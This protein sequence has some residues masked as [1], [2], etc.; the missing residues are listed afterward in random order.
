MTFPSAP[1][2]GGPSR[3]DLLAELVML[4]GKLASLPAIEQAK[5]ALMVTYGLTADAAFD[6]LRFH[7]QNRNVRI[8]AIAAQLTNLLSGGPT[9][10]KGITRFDQLLDE[11]TRSLQAAPPRTAAGD[12][13]P[14]VARDPAGPVIPPAEMPQVTLRAVA[15]APPGITIAANVP[16]LPLVYANNAF[17][18]LTGYPSGDVLGR[19]CRFLQG[20][21]TDL[22]D[23]ATLRRAL[24][25][26]RDVSV[27]LANYRSDGSPFWNEVSIS[28]IRDRTNQITHFVGTQTDVTAQ[29]EH[30]PTM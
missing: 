18:E 14:V 21:A 20:A 13:D 29:R 26:G 1:D 9:S 16:H 19:N 30:A 17:T 5:G 28:P 4:R 25:A 8:R 6:L 2:A 11:V 12:D 23:T 24:R 7:S 15:T 10:T 27:V 22:R 3:A